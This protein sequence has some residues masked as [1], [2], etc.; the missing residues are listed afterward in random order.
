MNRFQPDRDC[1]RFVADM[2]AHMTLLEKAG[3][4]AFRRAPDPG[5][6]REAEGFARALRA[7]RIGGVR[8]I[9]SREQADALQ[10]LAQEETRLGIPLLFSSDIRTG[11]ET[12]FPTPATMCASF[13]TA[14]VEAAGKVIAQ[15]AECR[16]INWLFGPKVAPG[17]A[18]LDDEQAFQAGQLHL[19]A[20]M[21]AALVRGV[22]AEDETSGQATLACLDFVEAS[23]PRDDTQFQNALAIARNAIDTA[24]VG[25]LA[26]HHADA[27][28]RRSLEEAAHEL[29]APGRYDGIVLAEW[30]DLANEA[31]FAESGGQNEAMPVDSLVEAVTTGR[32]DAN[33]LDEAVGRVLRAKYRIGLFGRALSASASAH[34]GPLPTPVH[35]REVSLELARRSAVLLRNQP[36]YLPLGIDSGDILVVGTAAS[37]RHLALAG[38]EGVAASVI[39]G[40]EQLGVPYRFVPGL[41]LRNNGT[42]Q[43]RMID[44]DRMAIGM[45]SEAA[46]RAGTIVVVLPCNGSGKLGE[47]QEQLLTSLMGANPR[48][49]LVTI[50][51]KAVD[52]VLR[53]K[54]LPVILHAGE[55]GSMGGHAIAELLTGEANPSGKLPYDLDADGTG[56]DMRFGHGENYADFALTGVTIEEGSN[57]IHV[58]GELRN[59]GERAGSET[60]QLYATPRTKDGAGPRRLAEFA[61]VQLRPG[62]SRALFFE[63]G[64]EQIGT[65][66][67]NG[68]FAVSAGEYEV[69]LG[70]SSRR[71][72]GGVIHVSEDLALAMAIGRASGGGPRASSAGLRSA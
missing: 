41:A 27:D 43:D 18:A 37:D 51:A 23:G 20:S 55:P 22:Q 40:L 60:I 21:A 68:R 49:V 12:V 16:G 19:V 70:T 56:E 67:A 13:D 10:Q 65:A 53:E 63:I 72:D 17:T 64:R 6:Q 34:R 7:G 26:F 2:L 33:R 54:R 45:A 46:K 28:L 3:Q 15:E 62:E 58:S 61:R 30:D 59:V 32:I 71:G 1:E 69:F 57:C 4:L 52:P 25:A 48:V 11:H 44:A 5:D 14:A 8:G 35:N 29:A 24:N 31:N 42:P 66:L 39:D 47:A 50:G 9:V 38:R 36:A